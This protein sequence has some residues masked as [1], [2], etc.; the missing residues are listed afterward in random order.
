VVDT[1]V[2]ASHALKI[3]GDGQS[4]NLFKLG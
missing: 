3:V 2:V 4:G 1:K